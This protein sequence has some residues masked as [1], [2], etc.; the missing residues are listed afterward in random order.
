VPL[1]DAEEASRSVGIYLNR[2]SDYLFAAARYAAMKEGK[3]EIVYSKRSG[4]R[5]QPKQ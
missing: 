4:K 5:E 3:P 2:L 1:I